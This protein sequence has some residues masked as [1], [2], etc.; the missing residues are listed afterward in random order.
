MQAVRSATHCRSA[1]WEAFD[2]FAGLAV[3]LALLERR[4]A[5]AARLLGYLDKAGRR[6][7]RV[8]PF[9]AAVRAGALATLEAEID[10]ATL[11]GLIAEGKQMDEEGVCALALDA[12]HD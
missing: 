2:D 7:G 12:S 6:L 11:E 8:T 9:G 5:S 10:R 3:R 4:Y 1:E